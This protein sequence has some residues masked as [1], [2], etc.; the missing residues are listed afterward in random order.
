MR[1]GIFWALLGVL[2]LT[3]CSRSEG[4]AGDMAA[5]DEETV[6]L[7]WYIN[8]TW[9]STPWGGNVVSDAIT[10]KTGV[11]VNF[12]SPVGNPEEKF[13]ALLSSD[14]LPD[15]ITLGWWENQA[16]EMI[17]EDMVYALNELADKYDPYFWEAA[18]PETVSWYTRE[19][20]NIYCY[21]S[22]SF[23]PDD[24]EEHDNIGSNQTF[25]VRKDI[26]EA[27]GCPDMSTKEG[28]TD[29]V[30]RAARMFPQVDGY[31]L[32][33][34]GAHEFNN[35]GCVSFDQYLQNFLAVP[36]EKEGKFYDR[37]TDSEYIGWLK[38][39]R[40]LGEEGYLT[41]DIFIDQRTQME[42]K[43]ARGQYFCMIYQRTDMAGIQSELYSKNL[44]R[45]Y[46]AVD[47]P[48]NSAGDDPVLPGGGINGWTVT[49]ISKDCSCP[50][51]AI[52]LFSYLIS[53]EGQKMVYLGVEGVT[54]DMVDGKPVVKKEVQELLSSDR[55]RYDA[56]Y[57]A[58]D[59]YWMF[60]DNVRQLKWRQPAAPPNG[61]LEEW[62]FPYTHYMA[63]YEIRFD[64][65]SKAGEADANIKKLWSQTLPNLLL[66][67]TEE[68][69]DRILEE[70]TTER[71]KLGF[72]LVMEESTRQVQETKEKLSLQ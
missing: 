30:K 53:D 65:N 54:Y 16:D 55:G 49:F 43:M 4:A 46:M 44:N 51:R 48:R 52:K 63:Q 26:Y 21:P 62:T 6:T 33:P 23:T 66:A 72:A 64:R 19:D 36:Y 5:G 8:F 20:G 39:F 57:G 42:E 22:S 3:A 32:I 31:P 14:S 56:L 37:Y 7:D 58:D 59:A 71:E 11:S 47:G 50:D 40:E 12:L 27:L 68:E 61:Q 2:F 45:I 29:A 1:K 9:Y 18:D 24:Y 35:A 17:E 34:I 28:F 67:P 15:I 10:Q 69:F 60:Q 41:N 70:F 13:N 25:L 38:T